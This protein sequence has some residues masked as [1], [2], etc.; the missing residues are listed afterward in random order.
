[1]ILIPNQPNDNDRIRKLHEYRI[2][3]TPS[4]P[5]FDDLVS[6]AAMVCAVP[7]AMFTLIDQSR[8]WYK[9]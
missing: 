5:V 7:M 9:A 6:L 1:M 2:L 3:D 8:E 4:E